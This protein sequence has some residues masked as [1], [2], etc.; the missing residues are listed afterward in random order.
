[1][2][3]FH[4]VLFAPEIPQNTGTIGRLCVCTGAVLHLID[5]LGFQIDDAHLRRAGL[6][7]WPFLEWHRW[8]SWEEF[9]AGAK[10]ARM[11]FLSSKTTRS[12]FDRKATPGDFLVFGNEQ[13]GLPV[14]FYERYRDS[15]YTL[16]MPGPHARCHNLANAAAIALYEA[17]RQTGEI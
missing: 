12:F 9:L 13:H 5:P 2:P 16:P 3:P 10:P 14:E 8:S 15:L 1:M 17:L 6:D 11:A 4:I 7:Y